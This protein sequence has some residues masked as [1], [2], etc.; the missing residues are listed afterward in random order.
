MSDALD[1]L[2]KRTRPKVAPRDASLTART[3]DIQIS[4]HT[5][6][7]D[8]SVDAAT[9]PVVPT[10][11]AAPDILESRHIDIETSTHLD[12]ELQTKRSTFRLE[13]DL[14]DRLHAFCRR[15]GISREVLIEAMFEYM[16]TH[17]EAMGQ[18]LTKA[19]EKHEHR[20]QLANRKRAE[21]MM[22]RF[23]GR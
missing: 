6:S 2:K 1:R 14:I 23:G 3:E 10:E 4:R 16:E 13:A 7:T 19:G 12:Q 9:V 22:Q 8:I 17:P 15:Q 11:S 5:D 20:Q 21:A 18:A